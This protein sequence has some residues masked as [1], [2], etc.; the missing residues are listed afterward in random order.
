[1][2]NLSRYFRVTHVVVVLLFAFVCGCA[3]QQIKPVSGI[4]TLDDKPLAG[5][6]VIFTPVEGGRR[7]SVGKTDKT[8][9]YSLF[10][11]IR[12][13]GGALAGE[14]KVMISKRKTT[15]EV[16]VETLPAKYNSET[17]FTAE[18]TASGDNKFNFNLES[19]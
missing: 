4:V 14:Y 3:E 5:V 15:D 8:G 1:M 6:Q 10:Y 13:D 2:A 18:V 9:A 17:I 11:T 19:K 7:N 16:E 12:D